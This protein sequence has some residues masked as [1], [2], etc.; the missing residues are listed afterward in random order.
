M[1]T[2]EELEAQLAAAKQETR[3]MRIKVVETARKYAVQHN[4]C[5]VVDEALEEAGLGPQVEA[6]QV[7][8]VVPTTISVSVDVN[9]LEGMSDDEKKMY[10]ASRL[11]INTTVAPDNTLLVRSVGVGG[12]RRHLQTVV[13]IGEIEVKGIGTVP[14]PPPDPHGAPPGYVARYTSND[15]RVLHFFSV[16]AAASDRTVTA[17]CQNTPYIYGTSLREHSVRGE[18]RVCHA[19][20][21]RARNIN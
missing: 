12:G 13:E 11:R 16:E 5:T 3:E 2:V 21:T 18:N 14:P 7:E 17:V 10:I 1:A 20:A 19:C 9:Q 15:G 8:L 4:L 6:I